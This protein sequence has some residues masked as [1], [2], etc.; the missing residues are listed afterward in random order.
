LLVLPLQRRFDSLR[1][2]ASAPSTVPRR[3]EPD[4]AERDQRVDS[5][6]PPDPP[7]LV[8]ALL[9]DGAGEG[10][11]EYIPVHRCVRHKEGNV[12]EHLPEPDRPQ[13]KRR[14]WRAWAHEDQRAWF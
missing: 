7:A 1:S 11:A 9:V 3:A 13:V 8:D 14:L 10:P 2:D 12:L 5:I 6:D 4:V